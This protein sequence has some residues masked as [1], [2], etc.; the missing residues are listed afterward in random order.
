MTKAKD[1]FRTISEASD[2]LGLAPHVLRHWEESFK[3]LRPMRRAGGRR[4]YRPQD[5]ELMA[6]IKTLLHDKGLTTKGVQKIFSE[7]GLSH[8]V[9]L[10]KKARG[11][12]VSAY[13]P[14][15]QMTQKEGESMLQELKS[16]RRMVTM[17]RRDVT[18]V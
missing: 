14:S 16:I 13:H 11:E 10:G 15:L 5:I 18:G 7:Q 1:A 8:V 17:L 12:T 9:S 4:Y 2:E 3:A 6:G